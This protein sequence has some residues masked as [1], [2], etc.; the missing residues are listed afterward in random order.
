MAVSCFYL[1][2]GQ[3]IT[4]TSLGF[5]QETRWNAHFSVSGIDSILK[6]ATEPKDCAVLR[7]DCT[8]Y[9][10]KL[11]LVVHVL[12]LYETL[13]RNF[14]FPSLFIVCW[15][16]FEGFLGFWL[17]RNIYRMLKKSI[18]AFKGNKHKFYLNNGAL[19][20]LLLSMLQIC[21]YGVKKRKIQTDW[22]KIGF[23]YF[24]KKLEIIKIRSWEL[25]HIIWSKLLLVTYAY[26][27]LTILLIWMS[28]TRVHVI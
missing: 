19:K 14:R 1:T 22:K 23:L 3:C 5:Y 7:L 27:T 21:L 6:I 24:E 10:S 18:I 4:Y 2:H 28:Y 13:P 20:L 8:L 17:G 12:R 11:V 25:S 16:S 15:T 9:K 26:N